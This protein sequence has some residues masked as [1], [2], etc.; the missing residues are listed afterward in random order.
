MAV[1]FV[2]SLVKIVKGSPPH[3]FDLEFDH[4]FDH[5][6]DFEFDN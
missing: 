4:E 5:E 1:S 3:A 2:K 6:L